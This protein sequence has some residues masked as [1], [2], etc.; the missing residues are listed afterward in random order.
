MRTNLVVCIGT[1]RMHS[2]ASGKAENVPG[3]TGRE[4]QNDEEPYVMLVRAFSALHFSFAE[5][6]KRAACQEISATFWAVANLQ[7]ASSVFNIIPFRIL[8]HCFDYYI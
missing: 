4:A 6:A 8:P 1:Y 2:G 3:I 7:T 5:S